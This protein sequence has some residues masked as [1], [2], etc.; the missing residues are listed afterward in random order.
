MSKQKGSKR[1]TNFYCFEI[2]EFV[3]FKGIISA[4][5]YLK[6][7]ERLM[8]VSFSIL[9][10]ILCL[11]IFGGEYIPPDLNHIRN[12][13]QVQLIVAKTFPE[14]VFNAAEGFYDPRLGIVLVLEYNGRI[15]CED[16]ETLSVEDRESILHECLQEKLRRIQFAFRVKGLLKDPERLFFGINAKDGT[17]L[18]IWKKDLLD[19]LDDPKKGSHINEHIQP[20]SFMYLKNGAHPKLGEYPHWQ[21]LER[22]RMEIISK[23]KKMK[24]EA[25]HALFV[26]GKGFVLIIKTRK[27]P[28]KKM[29]R[30]NKNLLTQLKKLENSGQFVIQYF[31]GGDRGE[32]SNFIRVSDGFQNYLQYGSDIY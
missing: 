7:W 25:V 27:I 20:T 12:N 19:A 4:G 32:L 24:F 2:L 31:Y 1:K 8:K 15:D 17:R 5:Q 29:L 9:F 13:T 3:I 16:I 6:V 26:P 22:A 10:L 30:F 11:P 21:I 28:V 14:A 18:E 23:L